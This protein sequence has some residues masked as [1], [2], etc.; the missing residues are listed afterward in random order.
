MDE[1][2]AMDELDRRMDELASRLYTLQ[3]I[4]ECIMR[5]LERVNANISV[6]VSVTQQICKCYTTKI[7]TFSG[8]TQQN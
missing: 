2:I 6:A 8:V 5:D 1:V 7:D 4:M 3:G